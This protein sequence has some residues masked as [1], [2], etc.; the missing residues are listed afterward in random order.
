MPEA[1]LMAIHPTVVKTFHSNSRMSTSL[2]HEEKSVDRLS[3]IHYLGTMNI[4]TRFYRNPSNSCWDISVWTKVVDRPTDQHWHP[5]GHGLKQSRLHF[6]FYMEDG[7]EFLS[8][9]LPVSLNKWTQPYIMDICPLFPSWIL[10]KEERHWSWILLWC[11][12]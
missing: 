6:N 1:N 8:Y 7:T 10:C 2:W 11:S 3:R 12:L 4:C 9:I 5:W